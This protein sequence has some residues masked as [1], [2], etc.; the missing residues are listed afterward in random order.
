MKRNE[1]ESI[2]IFFNRTKRNEINNF[3][4]ELHNCDDNII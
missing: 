3:L 2:R 4:N 1:Y